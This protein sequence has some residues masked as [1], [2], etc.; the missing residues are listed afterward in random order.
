VDGQFLRSDEMGGGYRHGKKQCFFE[1]YSKRRHTE[2]AF[3]IDQEPNYQELGHLNGLSF[4]FI[5]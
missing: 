5:A 2:S 4:A 1:S 3:G